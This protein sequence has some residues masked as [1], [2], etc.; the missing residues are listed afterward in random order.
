MLKL[1]K[2]NRDKQPEK[3]QKNSTAPQIQS[4]TRQSNQGTEA[5]D[6]AKRKNRGNGKEKNELEK[7]LRTVTLPP[8]WEPISLK[9]QKAKKK[10]RRNRKTLGGKFLTSS[11][12]TALKK[13]TTPMIV[14]SQ[15]TATVFVTSILM[16]TSLE[17][18]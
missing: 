8:Q 7:K 14:P 9:P 1:I 10:K 11:T 18:L 12:I 13:A 5:S 6:K 4:K 2:E 15:K 17:V 16:T 3:A